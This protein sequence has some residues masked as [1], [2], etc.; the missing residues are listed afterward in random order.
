[1]L[2]AICTISFSAVKKEY[3]WPKGKMP[4]SQPQQIAATQSMTKLDGF[5]PDK[6]RLPYLEWY[7]APAKSKR[8][9]ACMILIRGGS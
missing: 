4:D 5:N 1:M 6:N 2:T 9:G 7:D 8:K 3:L